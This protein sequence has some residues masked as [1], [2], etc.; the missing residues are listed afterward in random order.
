MFVVRGPEERDAPQ[1]P[2]CQVE[3]PFG[4]FERRSGRPW[5]TLGR[6]EIFQ[7]RKRDHGGNVAADALHRLSHA[8]GESGPQYFV[9]FGNARRLPAGVPAVKRTNEAIGDRDVVPRAARVQARHE[10]EPF[11]PE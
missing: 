9:A 8:G 2:L 10:P 11:L 5:P 1:R 4:H 7:L 6:G 3:W